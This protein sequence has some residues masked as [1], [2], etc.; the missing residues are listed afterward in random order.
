MKNKKYKNLVYIV[1]FL[2]IATFVASIFIGKYNLNVFSTID[3]MIHSGENLSNSEKIDISVMLDIRLPRI[4]MSLMVGIG[5]SLCGTT[6]QAVLKNPLASPDILGTSSA[7][8]FGAALGLLLF[9]D[10]FIM[11]SILSFIFGI[12]S[13]FIVFGIN[14]LKRS[15]DILSLVLAG[16]I[17]RSVFMSLIAL[18]K[19]VADTEETLP[20]ITFWLMGSFASIDRTQLLIF[21]PIL[22]ICFF[23]L[24]SL[25][26]KLN[27]I[28]LG[29]EEAIVQKIDPQKLKIVLLFTSSIIISISVTI[30]GMIGW[31]GLV[32]PHLARSIVRNNHGKLLPF[33]GLIGGLYL[34]LIDDIARTASSAEIPIGILTA[35]IGA[36]IFAT[37]YILGGR[38][39]EN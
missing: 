24:Y 11:V 36:P 38:R 18:I 27:I 16:I 34:L 25:R 15:S 8:A 22:L 4:I 20:A 32:I 6:Y 21:V 31:V 12:S 14:K 26:W 39:S 17:V 5:L 28:S 3:N 30:S 7:A 37:L 9:K 10:S 23:I 2:L 19:Y 33:S 29:D 13:I 1:F 35:F